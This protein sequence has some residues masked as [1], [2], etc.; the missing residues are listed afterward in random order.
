MLLFFWFQCWSNR[1]ILYVLVFPWSQRCLVHQGNTLCVSI[2]L[3]STLSSPPGKYF[4]VS[5]FSG[6]N[7]G[8]PVKFFYVL[9]F[10]L[11]QCCLVH[12]GNTLC[13]SISLVS[14]QC[15]LVHQGNTFMWFFLWSQHWS[16]SEILLCVID[17]LVPALSSPLGKCF[18]L[19]YYFQVFFFSD[20]LGKYFYVLSFLWSQS[21]SI[22]VY[23]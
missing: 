4:Y 21:L 7:V 8:P 6:L 13:V 10:L 3:V 19:C 22:H 1:E 15:C 9:L 11:S 17:S 2:S 5:F 20:S 14:S 23:S 18:I 12:Q 16:T